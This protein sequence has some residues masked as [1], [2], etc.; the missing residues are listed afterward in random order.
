M[1]WHFLLLVLSPTISSSVMENGNVRMLLNLHSLPFW[2]EVNY[3]CPCSSNLFTR[4]NRGAVSIVGRGLDSDPED[5]MGFY[6]VFWSPHIIV[7]CYAFNHNFEVNVTECQPFVRYKPRVTIV[8]IHWDEG[9]FLL[10]LWGPENSLVPL[11]TQISIVGNCEAV[12][13]THLQQPS[14]H[15]QLSLHFIPQASFIYCNKKLFPPS[16]WKQT[17]CKE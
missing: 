15:L 16:L 6:Q 14:L 1:F 12:N 11:H 5:C 13:Q 17:L 4:D 8:T 3:Q 10:F 7:T 9:W 2:C